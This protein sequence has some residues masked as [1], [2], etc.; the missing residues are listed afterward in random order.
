VPGISGNVDH[1]RF[2]GTLDEL[3]AYAG[4]SSAPTTTT[5]STGSSGS[6]PS[7]TV[8]FSEG[9]EAAPY[10]GC[11]VLGQ[12]SLAGQG[13]A[14]CAVSGAYEGRNVAGIGWNGGYGANADDALVLP[15]IDLSQ[16]TN[17]VL[18]FHQ[19]YDIEMQKD[20]AK[21]IVWD[22]AQWTFP[23]PSGGYPVAQLVYQTPHD[24][25]YTGTQMSWQT[26]TFDLGAYVGLT[27]VVVAFWFVSDGDD[28]TKPRGWGGFWAL[29]A[30]SVAER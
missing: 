18:V 6:N 26:Q 1:D 28:S 9:F 22:G 5:T 10:G 25:W 30:V 13:W 7:G 20:G 24:G 19:A 4:A 27:D 23:D 21:V 29:D 15:P 14:V 16:A 11:G 3:R 17:P 8:Y 2:N 12:A